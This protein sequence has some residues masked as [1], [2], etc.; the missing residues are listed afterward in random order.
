M[1]PIDLWG[2]VESLPAQINGRRTDTF[3]LINEKETENGQTETNRPNRPPQ[4]W[5]RSYRIYRHLI[6][7]APTLDYKR[8]VSYIIFDHLSKYIPDNYVRILGNLQQFCHFFIDWSYSQLKI[9]ASPLT[10]GE[11]GLS[12]KD[13]KTIAD[14]FSFEFWFPYLY[15]VIL[16]GEKRTSSIQC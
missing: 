15:L 1:S 14:I 16:I 2:C 7:L 4:Y 6:N 12:N 8:R 10:F 5:R 9:S 13:R 3:S 11:G